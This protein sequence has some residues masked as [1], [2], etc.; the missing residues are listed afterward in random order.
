M[1]SLEKTILAVI[2]TD[3]NRV[4]GGV[5]IFYADH[6]D[7]LEIIGTHLEVILDAMVH[8]LDEGLFIVVKHA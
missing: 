4:G 8:E 1:A 5:P 3:R 2:T 6:R 7:E